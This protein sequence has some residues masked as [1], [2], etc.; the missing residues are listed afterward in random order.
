MTE[1]LTPDALAAEFDIFVARAG[2]TIPSAQRPAL[3]I[4]YADLRAQLALL[5]Q[6]RTAASE[7]SNVFRL[8][9]AAA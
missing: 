7:P 4:G 3:L 1:T 8:V 9:P 6:P 2:L 5:R